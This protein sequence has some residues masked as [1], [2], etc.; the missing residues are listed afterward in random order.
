MP[1]WVPQLRR[2][3]SKIPIRPLD[4]Y[5]GTLKDWSDRDG[6][7]AIRSAV[8]DLPW[9]HI[10]RVRGSRDETWWGQEGQQF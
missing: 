8:A 10:P 4:S 1:S 2:Q 9:N 5:G 6:T 3:R 7:T